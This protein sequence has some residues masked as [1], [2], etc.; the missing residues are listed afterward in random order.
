LP[1]VVLV[2]D[3]EMEVR[4]FVAIELEAAGYIVWPAESA[5]MGL[6]RMVEEEPDLIT[7]DVLMPRQSGMELYRTIKSDPELRDL[8][9]LVISGM[10]HKTFR[11]ALQNENQGRAEPWPEPEGYIE[12]PPGPEELL[13]AVKR[14][15][16]QKK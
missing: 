12:K 15:L 8:P 6:A 11:H 10:A 7:L 5:A 14:I 16:G 9:V 3:D 4:T 2:I 13:K 1:K